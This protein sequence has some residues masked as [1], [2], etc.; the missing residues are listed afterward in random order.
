MQGPCY[1]VTD[2]VRYREIDGCGVILDLREQRYR[3]LDELGTW[4]WACLTGAADSPDCIRRWAQEFDA[5]VDE[6]S[7]SMDEFA[8][9]CVRRG[10]LR[11]GVPDVH[12][13]R[14]AR[15]RPV[16][17]SSRAIDARRARLPV[18]FRWLPAPLL[19][20]A[21]LASTALSLRYRGFGGTYRRQGDAR[22]MTAVRPSSPLEEIVRP[23]LTAENFMLVG[24]APYD[25]L[26]RSLALFRYL[27]WRGIPA[28]HVIG[29]RRVPFIAHAW[30]EICGEGVLAPRPRGFSALAT[31][32]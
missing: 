9:D 26:A 27:R 28:T 25:C 30:V 23:F 32:S 10:F 6:I 18:F 22:V 14:H 8:A 13:P 2:E 24:R 11:R 16:A 21:A 12:R 31:L 15:L 29:I 4:M 19:A 17:H 7:A 20:F 3:V 5:A 1:V